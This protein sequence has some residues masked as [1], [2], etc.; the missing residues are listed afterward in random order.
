MD[1]G[2]FLRE[3][4]LV[5]GGRDDLLYLWNPKQ[6]R[7]EPA[8]GCQGSDQ[9]R[10]IVEGFEPPIEGAFSATLEDGSQVPL[11]PVG[12]ILKQQLEPW[13][14]EAAAR[15]TGL[16]PGLIRRFADGFARSKRPMIFSS[17]G[18]NRF[19]HSDL[20]N[21]SKLLCLSMKGAIG[22][23]GSGYHATAFFD[24]AGFGSQ[25]Q[26][27]RTGL[28][29]RLEM[30]WG[31]LSAEEVFEAIVD[32]VKERKSQEQIIAE[33][34]EKGQDEFVCATNVATLDYH[35]QGIKEDLDRELEGLFPR[36]LAAYDA[37]ATEKGWQQ[38]LPR[39]GRPRIYLTGG[40][41]LLRRSNQTAR[42]LDTLWPGIE[43][44]VAI[45]QKQCFTGMHADYLLP[46]AGWYEKS[47]IKYALTYVPYLHY[48]DAAVEPIGESKDEWEIYWLLTKEIEEVAKRRN[49]PV[50]EGC[51][52][53]DVD[54]KELHQEYSCQ[55]AFGPKDAE[56]VT[57][58]V[59][60]DSPSALGM[61]VEGLKKTGVEKFRN[62]GLNISP[63]FLYNPD[64]KGEGVLS[65][66][67]HFVEYKWRW[68]TLTGRQQ[69][70]IDH[71]WF[72]EAGEALPAHKESP[73]AGGDYP[74]QLVSSHCRWSIHTTWRDTSLLLRLQRG[75]PVLYL[76]TEEATQ[77]GLGD[78]TWAELY[79]RLGRMRMRIKHS[80]MVQ[81]GVAFYFHAWEPVQ[82]PEHKS[83][84]WL[85]PGPMKPL[86]MAGG[87]GHLRFGI[88]H[89]EP[90]SFVQDT[91]VGIRPWKEAGE[92]KARGK[93]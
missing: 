47:G 89:F 74:F 60:D 26:R 6:R 66:L 30:I 81:P 62:T 31:M 35:Y 59:I 41:N 82:F 39:K 55:G 5:K 16:A 14:F 88:N 54:W 46:A 4:D 84:K 28:P 18:S 34:A 8:P 20:M 78:G 7:P 56:K 71:P 70:Y 85:I 33:L 93:G 9:G 45:D 22:R 25:L 11:A 49:S 73:R 77:L 12:S 67:T 38:A 92:P 87:E 27:S 57:Q 23:R 17:W 29:G 61:S 10:L 69:F 3:A 21:R 83:Y 80:S 19:I 48:C 24:L 86:H 90:G 68:P 53:F 40:S 91:R 58:A 44:V 43:L 36:P 63:T 65:P 1:T 64:W 79:N 52:K 51:G 37:E 76:N 50:F 72:L 13:S 75:E 32:L 2:R 15:V 42:M